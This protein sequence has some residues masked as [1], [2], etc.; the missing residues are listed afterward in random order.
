MNSFYQRT[1]EIKDY[2]FVERKYNEFAYSMLES[3]LL[4]SLGRVGG[5]IIRFRKQKYIKKLFRSYH[6][7]DLL[8]C[9]RCEAHNDLFIRALINGGK[10]ETK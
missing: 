8:N 10:N 3:Y 6:R 1:E 9:L 7:L 4:Q 2:D 5:W